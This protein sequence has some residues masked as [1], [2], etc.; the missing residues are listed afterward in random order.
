[1]DTIRGRRTA[2]FLVRLWLEPREIAGQDPPLRGYIRHLQTGEERYLSDPR[3]IAEY[4]ECQLHAL[5]TGICSRPWTGP[6][7][8]NV[9]QP[10]NQDQAE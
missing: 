5:C 7:R 9:H 1:M 2:S 4:V 3:M 6:E 8:E 10:C